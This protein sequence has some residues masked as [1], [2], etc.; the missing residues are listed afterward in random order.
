MPVNVRD[1]HGRT[2]LHT[3]CA[4][5]HVGLAR[6]LLQHPGIIVNLTDDTASNVLHHT[7]IGGS[8]AVMQE[9]LKHHDVRSMV[10][11]RNGSDLSPLQLATF[12]NYPSVI[13][14]L[15]SECPDL[16]P[17]AFLHLIREAD[18]LGRSSIVALLRGSSRVLRRSQRLSLASHG[19]AQPYTH[20]VQFKH[21]LLRSTR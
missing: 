9:L 13:N 6:V 21:T 2:P 3:A 1:G 11:D 19:R 15:L 12:R 10:N 16:D 17:I 4:H 8:S 20:D 7:C 14:V 18:L 5:G